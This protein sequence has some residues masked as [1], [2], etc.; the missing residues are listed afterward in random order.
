[1]GHQERVL[2]L[3]KAAAS[4]WLLSLLP[5]SSFTAKAK[6]LLHHQLPCPT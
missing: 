5:L 6:P 3:P 2:G 1:M 4:V